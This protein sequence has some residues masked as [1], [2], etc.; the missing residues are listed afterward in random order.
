M[1]SVSQIKRMNKTCT[2]LYN[3]IVAF[4]KQ[5]GYPPTTREICTL[6]DINS[7][8][9]ARAYLRVLEN[10]HWIQMTN[11]KCRT[12]RLIRPTEIEVPPAI[13]E[14]AIAKANQLT[15]RR[16]MVEVNKP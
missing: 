11:G 13:R 12:M 8:S 16:L 5:F 1:K 15:L 10:W 4:I 3:R 2:T 6:M 7:T 14:A 9:Q